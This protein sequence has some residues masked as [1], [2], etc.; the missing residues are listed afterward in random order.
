MTNSR[1]MSTLGQLL[2]YYQKNRIIKRLCDFFVPYKAIVLRETILWFNSAGVL[3]ECFSKEED[4]ALQVGLVNG[5]GNTH[6][7]LSIS[8]FAVET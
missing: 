5:V 2:Y 1:I 8:L 3:L 7:V 4:S 6:L